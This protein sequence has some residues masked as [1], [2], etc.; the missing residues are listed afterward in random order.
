MQVSDL[1]NQLVAGHPVPLLRGQG[2]SRP[3]LHLAPRPIAIAAGSRGH[4]GVGVLLLR[5][6]PL[7]QL[8]TDLGNYIGKTI[9]CLL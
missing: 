9:P 4:V 6:P 5:L 7:G 1:C 3:L 8:W 2:Q